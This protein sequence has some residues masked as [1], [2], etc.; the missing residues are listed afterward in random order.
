MIEDF[1]NSLLSFPCYWIVDKIE[2]DSGTDDV[3]IYVRF[4]TKEY[5][6]KHPG[7]YHGLHD[8]NSYRTWRH[9]DIL[10]YKTYIGT[11]INSINTCVLAIKVVS[12]EEINPVIIELQL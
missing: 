9:L 7:L 8:Y 11:F 6:K 2:H 4:D 5:K 1:F 10:Q 12:C 3:F